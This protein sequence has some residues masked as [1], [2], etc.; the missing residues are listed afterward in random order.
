MR[1]LYAV[2]CWI[3]VFLASS[4]ARAQFCL[5]SNP[6]VSGFQNP[7]F[8]T[9]ADF[10]GDARP[11]IVVSAQGYFA[12]VENQGDGTFVRGGGGGQ[13]TAMKY[14]GCGDFDG[15]GDADLITDVGGVAAL[16]PGLGNGAFATAVAAGFSGPLFDANTADLD[17]DGLEDALFATSLTTL[18]VQLRAAGGGMHP[19]VT[20]PNVGGRIVPGDFDADGDIDV[21]LVNGTVVMMMRNAGNG[22]LT[23]SPNLPLVPPMLL[24]DAA[25]GDL[26]GD[27]DADLVIVRSTTIPAA[28]WEV[29]ILWNQ[30]PA[31]FQISSPL[32]IPSSS[33]PVA[34]LV[35]DLDKDG[36][37]D[38]AVTCRQTSL[39]SIWRGLGGGSLA[40]PTQQY[41]GAWPESAAVDDLD[42][43]AI[44]DLVT[45]DSY[46]KTCSILFGRG[47]ATFRS[48][49][50]VPLTNL[51]LASPMTIASGDL[52]G[53]S[54]PDIA[55]TIHT[56]NFLSVAFNPGDGNFGPHTEITVGWNPFGIVAADLDGDGDMD[57]ANS[58]WMRGISVLLNTG[59][60]VF[61]PP[62]FYPAGAV[63]RGL[64]AADLDADGDQDLAVV[65]QN[66]SAVYV[67][68]NNGNGTFGTSVPIW[69]TASPLS[70]A[71]RDLD[72][73]GDVDLAVGHTLAKVTILR[74]AGN[75]DFPLVSQV[76]IG[77]WNESITLADLDNDALP[78]I[79][80]AIGD[81]RI[82]MARN[83]GS[84]FFAA[85][86]NILVSDQ[87]HDVRCTDL[88]GDG[89]ADL[90]AAS[91]T[92]LGLSLL[93]NLGGMTFG[94]KQE[95]SAGNWGRS[96]AVADFDLDGRTD[97]AMA[98]RYELTA[99]I[100]LRCPAPSSAFCSGDG[101]GSACPCGVSSAGRGCPNS[102]F[103]SGARLSTS[104]I[105]RV[106]ADST[107]LIAEWVPDGIGVLVQ[108]AQ[109]ASAP[110][111]DGLLCVGGGIVRLA[112]VSVVGQRAVLPNN[113]QA[114]ALSLLSSASV[115]STAYYQFV[116][117]DPAPGYCTSATFN[118]TN[119]V[120][121]TWGP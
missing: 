55:T 35:A 27:G 119:G 82:Y 57:L 112:I 9:T 115:G 73:D 26:D 121:T 81:D 4:S 59:G 20:Y 37:D 114:T 60:G 79:V 54:Y 2:S 30:A 74:N 10:D 76:N 87:M 62:I 43:D 72:L 8:V 100:L 68:P 33:R 118:A 86:T 49:R 12:I 120:I 7:R 18:V 51:A 66:S 91:S 31:P 85:A 116:Y 117:R 14:L 95:Y 13:S 32:A 6:I 84:G 77:W 94:P 45:V 80:M 40:P 61:A 106:S 65:A 104:G 44:L 50:T 103:S 53:D 48:R 11:E 98:S 101:G 90:A 99:S 21:A 108:G 75:G 102:A 1:W 52:N 56:S 38:L 70:I 41:V 19:L 16:H 15:D 97:L 78:E 64:V 36:V 23:Q 29:R 42:G 39:V 22:T 83:L 107:H 25:G 111:G 69:I 105:A 92:T 71:A 34:A 93:K 3:G 110:F 17:G 88:D 109:P 24:L 5:E 63:L 46:S 58:N 113:A 89:L 28:V 67:L 96:I 47:D